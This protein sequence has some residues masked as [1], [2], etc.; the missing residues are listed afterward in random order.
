MACYCPRPYAVAL[1][2]LLPALPTVPTALL[3]AYQ[4][5]GLDEVLD[6]LFFRFPDGVAVSA[7]DV[8]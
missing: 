5:C 1:G 4:D 6:G 7:L 8:P 2:W 3:V